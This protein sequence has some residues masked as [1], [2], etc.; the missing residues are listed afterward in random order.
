MGRKCAVFL[1]P[2]K[3]NDLRDSLLSPWALLSHLPIRIRFKRCFSDVAES[4]CEPGGIVLFALIK[5]MDS[6]DIKLGLAMALFGSHTVERRIN[7]ALDFDRF[8][9][10][11]PVF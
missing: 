3:R 6:F 1:Q 11:S 2:T 8:D 10:R 4:C 5:D 7:N 9:P